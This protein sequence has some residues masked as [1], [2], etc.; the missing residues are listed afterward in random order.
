MGSFVDDMI[1][2][3]DQFP[4][5]DVVPIHVTIQ[6]N[7]PGCMLA[8]NLAPSQP[9]RLSGMRFSTRLRLSALS[10]S[11]RGIP[12]PIFGERLGTRHVDVVNCATCWD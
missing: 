11:T 9:L 1:P 7:L 5:F 3:A 2:R 4:D 10:I 6:G 8:E 12:P